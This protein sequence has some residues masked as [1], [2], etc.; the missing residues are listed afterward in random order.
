[1]DKHLFIVLEGIDN[2]GKSSTGS[3]LA[4]KMNEINMPSRYYKTPPHIFL[5][6]TRIVNSTAKTDAHFLYHL[7][8]VKYAEQEIEKILLKQHVVC[9]RYFF[10]TFAY[11]IAKG[12]TVKID[13]GTLFKKPDFLFMLRTDDE[14]ERIRRATEKNSP[15]K[16]DM[17]R[18][19]DDCA[20]EKIENILLSF[21]PITIENSRI[22][23]DKVVDII[24]EKVLSRPCV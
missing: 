23:T 14:E 22:P 15:E 12:S 8:M 18:K 13:V 4:E 20:L 6:A 9:D 19:E 17:K 11:H 21:D 2:V 16:H 10:S 1:M 5:E 3:A 24:L 7:A